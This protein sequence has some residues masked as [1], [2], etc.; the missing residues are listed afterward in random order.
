MKLVFFRNHARQNNSTATI[1]IRIDTRIQWFW[2]EETMAQMFR[3]DSKHMTGQGCTRH[4]GHDTNLSRRS[5]FIASEIASVPKAFARQQNAT[6]IHPNQKEHIAFH[7]ANQKLSPIASTT[8]DMAWPMLAAN[9]TMHGELKH[10]VF[11]L[12]KNEI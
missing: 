2:R 11:F 7:A 3:F 4:P 12:M 9:A 1:Q 6:D 8:T 5:C 10:R